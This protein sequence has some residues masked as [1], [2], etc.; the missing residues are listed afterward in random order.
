MRR[1]KY[2]L[3]SLYPRAWRNRYEEE[4]IALLEQYTPSW[5]DVFD[6]FFYALHEQIFTLFRKGKAMLHQ[7]RTDTSIFRISFTLGALI[8]LGM[9]ITGMVLVRTELTYK[10]SD[11][12][13]GLM[14]C[15]I[16]ILYTIAG[17][18]APYFTKRTGLRYAGVFGLIAGILFLLYFAIDTLGNPDT[19]LDAI[20]TGSTLSALLLLCFIAGLL[21]MRETRNIVTGLLV[22]MWT[23]MI[24]VLIGAISLGAIVALFTDTI[25][26]GTLFLQD[27]VNS[28]VPNV[29]DFAILDSL[30]GFR[31]Q[32]TILPVG[33]AFLGAL[34]GVLGTSLMR[35]QMQS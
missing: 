1:F 28:G 11:F 4:F 32:L 25:T 29:R 12:S 19:T 34:G 8:V 22:G 15:I 21:S 17:W 2:W 24:A 26:H 30:S 16:L 23:A 35:P 9:V 14:S 5:L 7:W 31:F 27:Y 20:L 6:I 33:G 13:N 18:C 3:L 10:S